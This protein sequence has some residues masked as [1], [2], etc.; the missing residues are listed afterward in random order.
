MTGEYTTVA[1]ICVGHC[2]LGVHFDWDDDDDCYGDTCLDFY[3]AHSVKRGLWTRIKAAA[4][5][6]A[7][8]ES[9]YV[10]GLVL[11]EAE[12]EQLAAALRREERRL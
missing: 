10:H 9:N 7:K 8:G 3:T 2:T 1:C 11:G 4:R 5:L 12:R 6:I